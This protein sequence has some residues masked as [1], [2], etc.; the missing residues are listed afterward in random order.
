MWYSCCVD[1]LNFGTRKSHTN[2][3]QQQQ[4]LNIGQQYTGGGLFAFPMAASIDDSTVSRASPISPQPNVVTC[5][6]L[7]N[8]TTLRMATTTGNG[9]VH[10]PQGLQDLFNNSNTTTAIT[11]TATTAAAT[12][13]TTA[14]TMTTTTT[15]TVTAIATTTAATASNN[16]GRLFAIG[17]GNQFSFPQAGGLLNQTAG[18]TSQSLTARAS[19]RGLR[20]QKPIV[21]PGPVKQK[22]Q[23]MTVATRGGLP[24]TTASTNNSGD[25]LT[26]GGGVRIDATQ[27]NGN[28]SAVSMSVS[29]SGNVVGGIS[30][31]LG[32]QTDSGIVN[33]TTM[34]A[35]AM[36]TGGGLLNQPN[37][38]EGWG[39]FNYPAVSNTGLLGANTAISPMFAGLGTGEQMMGGGLFSQRQLDGNKATGT[40]QSNARK[41]SLSPQQGSGSNSTTAVA[42]TELRKGI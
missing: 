10:Q 18:S 14:T 41:L 42:A 1:D 7:V 13:T 26:A 23:R 38:M 16:T 30:R 39:V 3:Q 37:R 36:M 9:I 35:M 19:N 25:L 27:A 20:I 33:Q 11:T 15:N 21:S 17:G 8:Q 12:T 6:A 4:G 31:F 24:D 22:S 28:N 34:T 29:T 40:Y 2:V 32:H 5:G